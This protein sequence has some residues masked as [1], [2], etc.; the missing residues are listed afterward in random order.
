MPV[1]STETEVEEIRS[2]SSSITKAIIIGA[3]IIALSNLVSSG[4][5]KPKGATTT[6]AALAPVASTAPAAA[7]PTA[8]TTA[9]AAMGHFPPKGDKNAKVAVIEFADFRC[10][11]CEQYFTQ[12]ESQ[13]LK[14]YVDTGKVQYAFRH[15]EFLGPASIT[16]GNA[17]E[18]ANE[19]GKFWDY[20][21]WLYKNQPEETDTSMY[22]TDK[23]TAGAVT[24]GIN[25]PQFSSCLDATKYASNVSGDMTDGQTA[26]VTGTPSFIIGKLDSSGT[27][28]VNGQLL[29]GA[30][31]YSAF[32][33]AIDSA[34]Q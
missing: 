26:G 30:Q 15:Y 3:V 20:H 23:L 32:Q 8:P 19:Q 13:V 18:C 14:N 31:P 34:L 33:T 24:V 17:A 28:V 11:F 10:P 25:G 29:V 12:T 9:T 4:I 21:D 7:A 16:A 6:S 1:H 5:I 2:Q 27:K 22:V